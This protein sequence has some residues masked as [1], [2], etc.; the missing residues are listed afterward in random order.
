MDYYY[1]NTDTDALEYSPHMKWI[2]HNHAFT[3]GNYEK[4]GVK[5][6]E[7]LKRGDIC[8]MYVKLCGVLAAGQVCEPWN[9]HAYTGG[10][11]LIYQATPHAEY[12]IHVDWCYVVI[13]Q[14]I[15][16]NRLRDIIGWM[17]VS[18]LQRITDTNA[19]K[20]LLK[21]IRNRASN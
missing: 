14:P 8:F 6:L 4:Y 3:S 16:L 17:P 20:E 11:R 21:E 18:T 10:D 9:G 5:V 1:I 13:D 2:E 12:R 7:R 15:G 19:A